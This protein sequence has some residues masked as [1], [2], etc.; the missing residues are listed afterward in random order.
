MEKIWNWRN[1][2]PAAI[3]HG[4]DSQ[5]EASTGHQK[6]YFTSPCSATAENTESEKKNIYSREFHWDGWNFN[7]VAP[8]RMYFQSHENIHL[9]KGTLQVTWGDLWSLNFPFSNSAKTECPRIVLTCSLQSP[10]IL[11]TVPGAALIDFQPLG[12]NG[13]T[14]GFGRKHLSASVSYTHLTLPTTPYV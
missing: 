7:V 5:P 3:S 4:E 12:K 6:S 10:G 13:Q 9:Q 2:K 1:A 14:Y 11:L 8:R